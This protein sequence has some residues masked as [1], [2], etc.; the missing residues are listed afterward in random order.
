MGPFLVLEL[1]R[2]YLYQNWVIGA[3]LKTCFGVIF[4]TS[5]GVQGPLPH[6]WTR[7][8]VLP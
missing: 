8:R 6:C 3:W 2:G 1:Q 7:E 5:Q 4:T